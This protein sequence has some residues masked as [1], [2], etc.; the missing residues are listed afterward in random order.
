[1]RLHIYRALRAPALTHT[2]KVRASSPPD[3]YFKNGSAPAPILI[4]RSGSFSV[5]HNGNIPSFI[6]VP[7][8]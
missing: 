1:M 3:P 5:L 4:K 6:N 2:P 7:F 8:R